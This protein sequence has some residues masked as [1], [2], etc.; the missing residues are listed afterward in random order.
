MRHSLTLAIM[1]YAVGL[2]SHAGIAWA[3]ATT[4]QEGNAAAQSDLKNLFTTEAALFAVTQHYGFTNGDEGKSCIQLSM[5]PDTASLGGDQWDDFVCAKSNDGTP[6]SE[7]LSLGNK[8]AVI[9][10][11][12]ATSSAFIAMAK[13]EAGDRCYAMDSD[14]TNIYEGEGPACAAGR[15]LSPELIKAIGNTENKDDLAQASSSDVVWRQ[16]P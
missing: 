5:N 16:A 14:S 6:R 2:L 13:H 7:R 10:H 15:V 3:D 8:V 11:T 12:N 1:V 9:V 4:T